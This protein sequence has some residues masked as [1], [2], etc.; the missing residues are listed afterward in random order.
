M[1]GLEVPVTQR[2]VFVE[3]PPAVSAAPES[4][5][6]AAEACE[7]CE[8]EA[9]EEDGAP[10]EQA[11]CSGVTVVLRVRPLLRREYGYPMAAQRECSTRCA[12]PRAAGWGER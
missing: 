7:A 10:E 3:E 9:K 5:E 4:A 11:V 12:R 1:G 8:A 2:E 6:E